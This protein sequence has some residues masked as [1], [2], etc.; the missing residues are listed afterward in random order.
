MLVLCDC[1]RFLDVFEIFFFVYKFAS[2]LVFLR[3]KE[4]EGYARMSILGFVC[5]PD[6]YVNASTFEN[7]IVTV[8]ASINLQIDAHGFGIGHKGNTVD[9]IYGL[10]QCFRYISQTDCSLCFSQARTRLFPSCVNDNGARIYLEGCFLRYENSSFYNQ[11]VADGDTKICGSDKSS[12][13]Q[14]FF[15]NTQQL[16]NELSNE[17][18]GNGGFSMGSTQ[19]PS[20]KIYGFAQCWKTLSKSLCRD[21]LLNASA[22]ILA[23][24]PSLEG[25]ALNAGCYMHY[26]TLPFSLN[27]TSELAPSADKNWSKLPIV[28][29]TIIPSV[30]LVLLGVMLVLWKKK[31]ILHSIDREEPAEILKA[32][33]NSELN[34]RYE[35]LQSATRNFNPTNKLGEGGFGS[36][37]KGTLPDGREID[38]KRLFFDTRQGI[39]E[40]LNE[41]NLISRVQHKNL[42]KLLGCSA[43]GPERLLVYEYHPN[44]GLDQFIFDGKRN[45]MLNWRMRYNIIVEIAGGLAYLHEESEIRIIHRDIKAS[46]ILLD[47]NYKPKIADFGLARYFSDD[48]SH[49]ST[50]V[51]GTLGYMAP[52]YIVH[53]QLTEKADI[54]SFGVLVL[55]IISGRK[56]NQ[57]IMSEDMQSDLLPLMWRHFRE[58]T[59]SSMLDLNL[60][61]FKEKEE[62]LRVVQVALLCTQASATLRPPMSKVVQML[63]NKNQKLPVP[64]EPPF[65]DLTNP[66]IK[67][68]DQLPFQSSSSSSV[69]NS[70]NE[71]SSAL[72]SPHRS[73]TM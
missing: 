43:Q 39:H 73:P 67:S 62:A 35:T 47:K 64:T 33:S 70:S 24:S 69:L 8:V 37:H 63:T 29:G 36:V 71:V 45:R 54:F 34:F 4:V 13:S 30:L 58:E 5:S 40:F 68:P 10:A 12:Q 46:N 57:L 15:E 2:Q 52:E 55:E 32:M 16:M 48:Q 72:I 56:N 18:P 49:I 61:E 22:K 1:Q 23:C 28:L 50:R 60:E 26:S 66:E 9:S 6:K 7:N 65:L 3:K 20:T 14:T 59:I 53:G 21:C 25:R 44:K 27:Q 11:T 31:I 42:V 19:G 41:V 38:V 51:A 17:A